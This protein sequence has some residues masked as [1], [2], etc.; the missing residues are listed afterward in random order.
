MFA[1]GLNGSIDKWKRYYELEKKII[2]DESKQI[3]PILNYFQYQMKSVSFLPRTSEL[4]QMPY[5]SISKE[6]YEEIMKNIKSL[7]FEQIVED[8]FT[9]GGCDGDICEIRT[10][11]QK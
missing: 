11:L 4:P 9:Q 6:K 7:E 3:E 10:I 1:Y 8:G 5:E 2:E